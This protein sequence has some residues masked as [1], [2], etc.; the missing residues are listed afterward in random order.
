MNFPQNMGNIKFSLKAI[1]VSNVTLCKLS[2]MHLLLMVTLQW[3]KFVNGIKPTK[4]NS[5]IEILNRIYFHADSNIN[6]QSPVMPH[7]L[8]E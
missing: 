6:S 4:A 3:R 1:T 7:Y 5:Y 2:N 8:L